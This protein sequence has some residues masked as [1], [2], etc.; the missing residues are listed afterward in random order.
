MAKTGTTSTDYLPKKDDDFYNFVKNLMGILQEPAESAPP[1]PGPSAAADV[2]IPLLKWQAWLIPAVKFETLMGLWNPYQRLYDIAQ[3]KK[4]R[5]SSDVDNHRQSR[6]GLEKYLRN[7]INQY[8]RYEDQVP[9]GEKVRMGIIPKDT[10][11]SP[12]HGTDAPVAGLK[13]KGGSVIDFRVRRTED[14][15]R[16]SMLKGY[17]VEVRYIVGP[18]IPT[19]PD[20]SG[21]KTEISSKA[22]FQITA[23]MTN[24]GK[25][26][27]CYARWRSKTDAKYNSP[28]TNLLQ[29]IIA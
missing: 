16:T 22:H 6:I 26:F 7:F 5:K 10:V 1:P 24:L 23:G 18:P 29:I 27:Y 13:N 25:T 28:W 20:M 17:V 14:Q 4:N 2:P 21:M 11:P 19:D 12:V 8:L 3:A 9:R 15:T